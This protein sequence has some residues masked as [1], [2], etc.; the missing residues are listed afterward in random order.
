MMLEAF[1]VKVQ[2]LVKIVMKGIIV[3]VAAAPLPRVKIK[4]T[5]PNGS[6]PT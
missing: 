2:L 1:G 3:G 6:T 5:S 4:L